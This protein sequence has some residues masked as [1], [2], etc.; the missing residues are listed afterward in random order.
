ME[1]NIACMPMKERATEKVKKSAP[2]LATTSKT[3]WA[4]SNLNETAS[5]QLPE[6]SKAE[7]HNLKKNGPPSSQD[8][9]KASL[10]KDHLVYSRPARSLN[11]SDDGDDDIPPI[12]SKSTNSQGKFCRVP[13]CFHSFIQ[14]NF[15]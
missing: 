5:S 9:T 15:V 4:V 1:D 13:V 6:I 10:L 12:K 8:V 7:E 3:S 11:T 2:H 14:P